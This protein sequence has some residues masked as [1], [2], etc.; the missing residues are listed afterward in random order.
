MPHHEISETHASGGSGAG[1]PEVW[2]QIVERGLMDRK[3]SELM[4]NATIS[5][6]PINQVRITSMATLRIRPR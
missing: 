5:K 6:G 3:S 4:F 2:V 1:P